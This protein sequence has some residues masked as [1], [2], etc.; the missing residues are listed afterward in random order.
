MHPPRSRMHP[1]ASLTHPYATFDAC[2]S[3]KTKSQSEQLIAF[4]SQTPLGS[5]TIKQIVPEYCATT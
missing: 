5:Q 3:K 1:H 4:C 2:V